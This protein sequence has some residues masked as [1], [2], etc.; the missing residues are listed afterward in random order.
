M[1]IALG[2]K[3]RSQDGTPCEIADLVLE[4]NGLRVTHL[5]VQPPE[6]APARLVPADLA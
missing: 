5:V 3:T 4:S 6:P 1:R 2:G